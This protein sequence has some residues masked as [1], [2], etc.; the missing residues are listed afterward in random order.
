MSLLPCGPDAFVCRR[1]MPLQPVLNILFGHG[2]DDG[3]VNDDEQITAWMQKLATRHPTTE[4]VVPLGDFVELYLTKTLLGC[5]EANRTCWRWVVRA[6]ECALRKRGTV[7]A[8]VQVEDTDNSHS[9]VAVFCCPTATAYLVDPNGT[10]TTSDLKETYHDWFARHLASFADA[11]HA[12]GLGQRIEFELRAVPF[13]GFACSPQAGL[14]DDAIVKGA[15]CFAWSVLF[16]Y[17]VTHWRDSSCELGS[18]TWKR[19][20]A[21]AFTGTEQPT[22]IQYYAALLRLLTQLISTA[23]LTVSES[24][25]VTDHTTRLEF[26]PTRPF[27]LTGTGPVTERAFLTWF[28]NAE[29]RGQW[30]DCTRPTA[31]RP[32]KVHVTIPKTWHKHLRALQCPL[33]VLGRDCTTHKMVRVNAWL[34]CARRIDACVFLQAVVASGTCDRDHTD[35]V[36]VTATGR[37]LAYWWI[38]HGA[39]YVFVT[40]AGNVMQQG[41]LAVSIAF[42]IQS[43]R[44]TPSLLFVRSDVAK[45][46]LHNAVGCLRDAA[47]RQKYVLRPDG[48]WSLP[49]VEGA[50]RKR[51][52]V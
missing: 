29:R 13:D 11:L 37:V 49:S 42:A 12:K 52:R 35:N 22:N 40:V 21:F 31:V 9:C 14:G 18:P 38:V 36:L 25:N 5:S 34:Q 8:T 30:D 4:R 6:F 2:D 3:L 45:V 48:A 1:G 19:R 33:F 28:R 50:P 39:V 27:Q 46:V 23:K 43:M 47:T 24:G 44:H 20:V 41:V 16:L 10:T 17:A 7:V 26:T 15:T 32:V 51:I